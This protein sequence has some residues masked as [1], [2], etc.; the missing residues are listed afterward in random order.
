MLQIL[1]CLSILLLNGKEF[2]CLLIGL[3]STFLVV[4]QSEF[5]S[6]EPQ[7]LYSRF[8]RCPRKGQDFKIFKNFKN[9][10]KKF[11]NYKIKFV[12][13]KCSKF[14]KFQ[15]FKNGCRSLRNLIEI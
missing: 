3:S 11:K 1:A 9:I 13:F 12:L 14:S 8:Q 10:S 6:R 7:W 4:P 2:C 15:I 5:T